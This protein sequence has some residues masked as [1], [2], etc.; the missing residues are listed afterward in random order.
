MRQP[1]PNTYSPTKRDPQMESF[2]KQAL[3]QYLTFSG[4]KKRG[5]MEG[6]G[7]SFIPELLEALE[8]SRKQAQII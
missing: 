3:N 4:K 5:V 2:Y 8:L 1:P 7:A 6:D